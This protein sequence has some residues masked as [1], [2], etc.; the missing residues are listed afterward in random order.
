M[1]YPGPE[2]V[3]I[4]DQILDLAKKLNAHSIVFHPDT[5]TDFTR[6]DEKV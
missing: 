3:E 4:I 6:L 2:A 1:K 5:V